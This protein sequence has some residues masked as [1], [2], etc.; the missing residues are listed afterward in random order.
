MESFWSDL[1]SDVS[2]HSGLDISDVHV[3]DPQKNI[4]EEHK[5]K[6]WTT[7]GEQ[8]CDF[9]PRLAI[10]KRCDYLCVAPWRRTLYGR[11]LREIKA[12]DT[13]PQFFAEAMGPLVKAMI[14]SSLH[15]G[16]WALMTTP[17]R[18]HRERN[19]A[20][21]VCLLMAEQ[22]GIP[23]YEDAVTAHNT[24]RVHPIFRLAR[25][26]DEN[27]VILFDDIVTTGITLETTKRLIEEHQK[28]III[29]VGIN[30]HL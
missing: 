30:N 29:F 13:M 27:N 21:R 23:F 9:S 5:R 25:L 26:P 2:T 16:G 18:R 8:R 11:T 14:G 22:L 17:K 4:F 15:R 10:V 28:N 20:T 19:F 24:D 12:D 7:S 1:L 6:Q 3:C